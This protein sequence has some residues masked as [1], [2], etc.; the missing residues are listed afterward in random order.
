MQLLVI[1]LFDH[2]IE[3]SHRPT[4]SRLVEFNL[5][6]ALLPLL[7]IRYAGVALGVMSVLVR[8]IKIDQEICH[9][10][11]IHELIPSL[12][13]SSPHLWS[14]YFEKFPLFDFFKTASLSHLSCLFTFLFQLK[15][16]PPIFHEIFR[17]VRDVVQYRHSENTSVS[18]M[19][20]DAS[21]LSFISRSLS[22]V[23]H[24]TRD[25]IWYSCHLFELF[26]AIYSF[27]LPAHILP[28]LY[29]LLSQDLELESFSQICGTIQIIQSGNLGRS[30]QY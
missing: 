28:M 22:V 13:T 27:P 30:Y 15:S 5:I 16:D 7:S 18:H 10:M 12:I 9:Q 3:L 26:Y 6:P 1:D 19:L 17:L 8:L 2:M 25:C 24:P 20:L 29:S 14:K 23:P 11:L 4:I 21:I